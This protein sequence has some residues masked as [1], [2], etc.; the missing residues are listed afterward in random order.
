[1]LTLLLSK[2]QEKEQDAQGCIPNLY[3]NQLRLGILIKCL[4]GA[5]KFRRIEFSS[6]I[7]KL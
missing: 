7:F 5:L 4:S 6:C 1:M 3:L 2:S